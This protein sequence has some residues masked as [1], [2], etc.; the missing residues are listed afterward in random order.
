MKNICITGAN[1]FIGY[2]LCK[3][4][5]K[6]NKPVIAAVRSKDTY[7]DLKSVTSVSIGEINGNTDWSKA[8]ENCEF[9]IHCAA[10]ANE[11]N[12]RNNYDYYHNINV[13]GTKNLAEQAV[14]AGVKKLIFLS[15]IKV[16]GENTSN[17]F[18]DTFLDKNKDKKF[19]YNQMPN[20][21]GPY[22]TSKYQAEVI[23]KNISAKTKLDVTIL[24][25]P[26][27]YGYGAKG[28][29]SSLIKLLKFG[30]PLPLKSIK[31]KRSMIGIDNLVDLLSRCLVQHE[32]RNKVFLVSDGEDLSTPNLIKYI[33]S[34]IGISVKLFSFPV[35]LLRLISFFLG[36]TREL[37]KLSESLEVDNEYLRKTMNWSP[38]ICVREGIRRMIFDK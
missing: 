10:K 12:N 19:K 14:K 8:L 6:L 1:G 23:L 25:L 30:I 13:A 37:K 11:V 29:L 21:K 35:I 31:N 20:P 16:N 33:S 34:S 32:S 9:V 15:S 17:S 26:L 24:R 4:F 28:N 3:N 5:S 27:V 18:I 7:L 22:A 2:A 36:K 38:P